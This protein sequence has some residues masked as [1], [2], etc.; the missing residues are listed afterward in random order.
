VSDDFT[1]KPESPSQRNS[2]NL[3]LAIVLACAWLGVVA[4]SFYPIKLVVTAFERASQPL[5]ARK[6]NPP[7]STAQAGNRE[8]LA[9]E[10][11]KPS[12][13]PTEIKQAPEAN[14]RLVLLNPGSAE[15]A[16]APQVRPAATPPAERS[17][18]EKQQPVARARNTDR[19]VLVVVRRRGPPYDTKILQGRIRDGRLIV[20]ARGLTIR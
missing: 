17:D 3:R 16:R 5:Q 6:E 12:P 18:P 20:N 13:P 2:L 1:W 11:G 4:G 7:S 9:L 8:P 14:T 15:P 19:N 10:P